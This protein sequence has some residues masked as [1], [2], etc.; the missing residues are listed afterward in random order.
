MRWAAHNP[1]FDDW[2]ADNLDPIQ[3][4]VG[5]ELSGG[6]RFAFWNLQAI[7]YMA[8]YKDE[9]GT[10]ED[11]ISS[12]DA[13]DMVFHVITAS[14]REVY[15]DIA[16]RYDHYGD[17]SYKTPHTL[18][19]DPT[20]NSLSQISANWGTFPSLVVL[21]HELEHAHQ[22]LCRDESKWGDPHPDEGRLKNS[23]PRE[24]GAM[25]AE[26]YQRYAFYTKVPGFQQLYPRPGYTSNYDLGHNARV[27]WLRYW[28]DCDYYPVWP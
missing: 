17:Y 1:Y 14:D 21:I 26:N 12:L 6:N 3:E 7:I 25:E 16:N 10:W 9:F 15:V 24:I 11:R 8:G 27:A 19:W 20:L 23:K 22:R 18:Y 28:R 5:W 2:G 13:T 4:R